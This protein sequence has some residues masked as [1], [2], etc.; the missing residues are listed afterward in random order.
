M[1]TTTPTQ[2]TQT[3]TQHIH[4]T[5]L[6]PAQRHQERA[7]NGRKIYNAFEHDLKGLREAFEALQTGQSATV[8]TLLRL[9]FRLVIH[10]QHIAPTVHVVQIP[11]FL[12][13]V[14]QEL[15]HVLI[16][17]ILHEQVIELDQKEERQGIEHHIPMYSAL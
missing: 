3:N 17:S 8:R 15:F 16:V 13:I 7:D 5:Y 12:C 11:H 10:F 1:R 2:E 14:V 9:L 6:S 4:T